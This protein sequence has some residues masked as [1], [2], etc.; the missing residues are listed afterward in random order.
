MGQHRWHV[1]DPYQESSG[2]TRLFHPDGERNNL[3]RYSLIFHV[4]QIQQKAF[5]FNRIKLF[6]RVARGWY[7]FCSF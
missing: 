2:R 7:Y 1:R 4:A 5:I 6:K 3:V